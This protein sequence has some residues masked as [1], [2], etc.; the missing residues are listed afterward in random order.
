MI[1]EAAKGDPNAIKAKAVVD[2]VAALMTA[3]KEGDVAAI[4]EL[5]T[6]SAENKQVSI[7]SVAEKAR[8]GDP[9]V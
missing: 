9:Q 7:H 8:R 5:H 4:G 6:L 2:E 1:R 3:A